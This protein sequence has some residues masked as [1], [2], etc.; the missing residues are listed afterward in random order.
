MPAVHTHRRP[1]LP[2]PTRNNALQVQLGVRMRQVVALIN[3]EALP[4]TWALDKATYDATPEAL[5]AT[6]RGKPV[7][8]I[9]PASGTLAPHSRQELTA[10][11]APAGEAL[12]NYNVVCNIRHKP[13][14]LVRAAMS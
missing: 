12:V 7:L 10:R 14:K 8:D 2:P 4:F 3:D 11:F 13:T 5:A 9:T 1:S 6:P